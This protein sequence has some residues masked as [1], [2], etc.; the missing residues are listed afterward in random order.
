M[1]PRGVRLREARRPP[2]SGTHRARNE[3][4]SVVESTAENAANESSRAESSA[5]RAAA[6]TAADATAS[7][8]AG[9]SPAGASGG[10]PLP[11]GRDAQGSPAGR[12]AGLIVY[13][14][15]IAFVIG[16]GVRSI[17]LR[18]FWPP[19]AVD[20]PGAA[21]PPAA[22]CRAGLESL[23]ESLRG[24]ASRAAAAP[25]APL[26]RD[27]F[28]AAWDLRYHALAPRCDGDAARAAHGTLARYRFSLEQSLERHRREETELSRDL[29][30]R[31]TALRP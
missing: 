15:L 12:R 19:A 22:S 13:W 29:D 30:A 11:A 28:F 27:A 2:V 8:A 24:F 26:D 23:A 6:S 14:L 4:L 21:P 10:G 17:T 5:P 3:T 25:S 9:S 20:A 7:T 18:V 31:L 16:F 1:T